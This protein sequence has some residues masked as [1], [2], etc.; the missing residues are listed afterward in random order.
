MEC[1]APFEGLLE[2]SHWIIGVKLCWLLNDF[3]SI[4]I[5]AELVVGVEDDM[6]SLDGD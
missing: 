3:G 5:D 6:I 2:A 1:L 4:N